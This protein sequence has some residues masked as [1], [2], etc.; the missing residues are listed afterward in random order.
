MYPVGAG[1]DNLFLIGIGVFL[2]NVILVALF[3]VLFKTYALKSKGHL[4]V[5]AAIFLYCSISS[6][7]SAF[8]L[9]ITL[10]LMFIALY[11]GSAIVMYNTRKKYLNV[12]TS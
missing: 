9:S 3:L 5:M 6:T 2:I 10:G 4:S 8:I 11:T 1:F 7:I 12:K